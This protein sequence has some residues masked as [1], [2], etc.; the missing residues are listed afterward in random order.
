MRGQGCDDDDAE[1]TCQCSA[2]H[3]AGV[4][5][6]CRAAEYAGI[7]TGNSGRKAQGQFVGQRGLRSNRRLQVV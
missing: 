4:R 1:F 6:N 5:P 7:L 3:H 2:G